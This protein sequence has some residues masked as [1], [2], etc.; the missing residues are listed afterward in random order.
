MGKPAVTGTESL[1]LDLD[2]GVVTAP[3]GVTIK[4]GDVV[5]IDGGTGEVSWSITFGRTRSKCSF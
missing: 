2:N 4:R 5:T 3:G 1:K